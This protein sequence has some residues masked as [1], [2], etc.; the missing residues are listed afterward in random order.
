M[1]SADA[2]KAGIKDGDMVKIVTA[3]TDGFAH[4]T[5]ESAFPRAKYGDGFRARVGSG[6]TAN[7]RIGVGVVGIP[8]HWGDRGLSTGCRANDLCIDAGDANTTMPEY[9]ACL[10][11]VEKI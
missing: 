8:Y 11:R 3:R 9:K 4:D 2:R 5:I 1:N 6:L 7:Q 10:C